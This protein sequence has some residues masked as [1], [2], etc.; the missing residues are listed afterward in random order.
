MVVDPLH[1]VTKVISTRESIAREPTFATRIYA[2]VWPF[3]VAIHAMCFSFVSEQAS[4]GRELLRS[5]NIDLA[6]EG[7][8]MGVNELAAHTMA[9]STTRDAKDGYRF[10]LII[11]LEL[12][13]LMWAAIMLIL[14][15][16]VVQA[17]RVRALA[18]ERMS[19]VTAFLLLSGRSG[20][21]AVNGLGHL[22]QLLMWADEDGSNRI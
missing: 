8:H 7:F 12:G 15:W 20:H 16:A 21:G 10:I 9:V 13:R 3:T 11:A 19:P 14:E 18:V 22:L 17:I 4:G 6:A 5:T 2:Q 1:V